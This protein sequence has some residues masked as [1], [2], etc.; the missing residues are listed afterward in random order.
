MDGAR[1]RAV[2]RL[3]VSAILVA[4][5]CARPVHIPERTGGFEDV[6]DAA[7][8][9]AVHTSGATGRKWYPE[10]FGSGVCVTDVDGDD[11]PDL[12]FVTG[13]PW[14]GSAD[15]EGV[16]LYRNRGDGTFAD[17]TALSRLRFASYGMG[18]AAADYDNDGRDDLLLTGYGATALFRN[19]GGGRFE[20]VTATAGVAVT[21]WSTCAVWF[22]ADADGLLDLFV[23]RYVQWSP[24]TDL[25]CRLD[26][27][28]KVFC[29]P[30]PYPPS[31]SRF[32]HNRGDGTFEDATEAAGL[33]KPAKALGAALLD[34]DGD[35]RVDLFVAND[36]VPNSLFRNRGDGTFEDWSARL[37]AT[38]GR[39][40]MARAGMGVDVDDSSAG[41]IVIGHF[42]GEGLGLYQR[43]A[44]GR[45][46]D[47]AR[48]AGL[49]E[50][51]LPFLTF[52]A[53]FIDADLDGWPDLVAANGHVD[54]ELVRTLEGGV[55]DRERP[56]F[57]RNL[58][59]GTYAEAAA[60][61]G[62]T[63]LFVGRGLATADLDLDGA[64]DLIFT[65]NNGPARLYRNRLSAGHWLRVRLK[66]VTSNR[67]G[68]GAVVT[69][70]ASGRVQTR[71]VRTGSS[72]L[73]QSERPPLFGLGPATSAETVVVR[74]PSGV[75][76]RLVG[77]RADQ[78][79]TITEGAYP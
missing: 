57:F 72:Y 54:A 3:A 77:A 55:T 42:M 13:R 74:W 23:C 56:L 68:I 48:P 53:V 34:V 37:A 78:R 52:G 62:L 18:C 17:I 79:M 6:T 70:A 69:V 7:G 58:G 25:A 65:E 64:P 9:R 2:W 24:E 66:G 60:Q 45:W 43:D 19:V 14:E 28:T 30:D 20:E 22:D 50:P 75:V 46:R 26:A 5:A 10:T 47:R 40:G 36:Q 31:T 33:A 76:D 27:N 21:G 63:S 67:D 32:F 15:R 51:S 8:V 1:R 12:L 61:V 71:M 41:G 44:D 4:A 73:S 35:G 16:A 49:F 29:G 11:R 59:D 38:P 39:F